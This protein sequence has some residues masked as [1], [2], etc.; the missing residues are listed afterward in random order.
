M[1]QD[2]IARALD[3]RLALE[4]P[5][6]PAPGSDL[7]RA[8]GHFHL[9]PELFLQVG[10]WTEF[11][12][13]RHGLRLQSGSALLL[14]PRLQ[15]AERVGAAGGGEPFSNLVLYAEGATLCCHLAHEAS[16]GRPG[17]LH[18]ESRHH[19]QS[20]LV[21]DWLRD[22]ARLGAADAA[23]ASPWATAQR[24]ALVAAACAGALRAL[25]EPDA[26][27]LPEPALVA[28]VRR[29]IEN[30]L[31]DSSLSVRRLAAQSGCTPDYLSHLFRRTTGEALA[32]FIVRQRM[33][34][35][36]RLLGDPALSGKEVAWACGFTTA[37]YFCRSFRGHFGATPQAWR[38]GRAP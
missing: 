27:V 12:F 9:A 18:L 10:G 25:D 14:P 37:S 32:A 3:G 20:A 29:L 26:H 4:V 11:R 5:A 36:A 1:L 19:P 2:F 33:E 8:A 15:H 31:G 34:R 6:G 38:A 17:I 23:P 21:H 7:A 30:Q 35:A 22:A 28:Q 13:P 24:R 16:A